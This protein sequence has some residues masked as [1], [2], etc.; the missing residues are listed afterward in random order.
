MLKKFPVKSIV[1][2]LMA[3]MILIPLAACQPPANDE[4]AAVEPSA[5]VESDMTTTE[6]ALEPAETEEVTAQ[7]TEEATETP[8]ATEAAKTDAPKTQAPKTEAPKTKAP[9]TEAP[10]TQAPKTSAPKTE[11][12]KTE[13]PKREITLPSVPRTVELYD[14]DYHG[15]YAKIEITD[16]YV[17]GG[18]VYV[19]FNNPSNKNMFELGMAFDCYDANGKLIKMKTIYMKALESGQ[20]AKGS[21]AYP[22]GTVKIVYNR[23]YS[24]VYYE[25][26]SYFG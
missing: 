24:G 18:Q 19:E 26:N 14:F 16:M 9:K 23:L 10:K 22:D 12:P 1:C 25:R 21:F 5:T 8:T 4:V 20:S 7:A 15:Y 2:L 11:S 17:S 3:L 13:E 6:P